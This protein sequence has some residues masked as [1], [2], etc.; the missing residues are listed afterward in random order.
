MSK[1][2]IALVI[3]TVILAGIYLCC[4]TDGL[5]K[6]NMG[7]EHAVRPNVAVPSQRGNPGNP[8]NPSAYTITFSLGHEY[9]LT[10]VKVVPAAE[11][12]TNP[13]VHPLWHLVGDAKS[14]PTRF[15]VYGVPIPGM[16]PLVAGANAGP[17]TYDVEYRLLVEAGGT[18]GEHDFKIAGP[19]GLHR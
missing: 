13:N 7:I 16:K 14:A 19:G 6:K 11:F 8:A 9:K 10:S 12:Q 4:F 5:K 1:K 17:L 2:E 18:R 15:I 3:F